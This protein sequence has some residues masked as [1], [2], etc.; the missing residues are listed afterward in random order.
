MLIP[1]A[2]QQ[3]ASP[4]KPAD[5]TLAALLQKR[6]AVIALTRKPI[7]ALYG[8]GS[9]EAETLEAN[10]GTD[11]RKGLGLHVMGAAKTD[12]EGH[13][14]VEQDEVPTLL[15][16]LDRLH[17]EAIKLAAGGDDTSYSYTTKGG[18]A[19]ELAK[20]REGV[21][22]ALRAGR[23]EVVLAVNQIAALR[24]LIEKAK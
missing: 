10:D 7:G 18:F 8:R 14:L 4:V 13:A 15:A 2:L 11:T 6:G 1:P 5:A 17:A 12:G 22:L 16:A 23:G 24:Q 19:L 3:P 9:V 20:T 21:T